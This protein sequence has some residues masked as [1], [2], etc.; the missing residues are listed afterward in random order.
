[1]NAGMTLGAN[2]AGRPQFAPF[3]RTADVTNVV[4][5]LRRRDYNSLQ[6]KIDRRFRN[7]FLITNSYT[8]GRG[9]SYDGGDS[10]G[11]IS[12]PADIELQLGP[13]RQRPR[14]HLRQQLRLWGLP[15][16]KDGVLGWLVN[17]WQLSGLFT[18]QIGTGDRHPGQRHAAARAGQHAAAEPDR[19]LEHHR[20]HRQRQLLVRHVGVLAARPRTRSAT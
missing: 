20:R 19:R 8:L 4:P 13:H 14:A 16:Q 3:G 17:G 15:V 5:A 12:T 10:N 9:E 11:G 1:M 6:V 18:A 2:D 7:S